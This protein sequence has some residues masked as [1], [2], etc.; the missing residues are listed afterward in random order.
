MSLKSLLTLHEPTGPVLFAF[1]V[2]QKNEADFA[3]FL[4]YADLSSL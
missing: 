3:P 2:A 1:S 4:C